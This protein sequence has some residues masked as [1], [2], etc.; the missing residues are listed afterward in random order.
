MRF[1]RASGVL[2]VAHH[3]PVQYISLPVRTTGTVLL[4]T[5]GSQILLLFCI[6]GIVQYFSTSTYDV[7]VPVRYER[8]AHR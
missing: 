6:T 4:Y 5:G 3:L 2:F 7:R 8:T 1:R